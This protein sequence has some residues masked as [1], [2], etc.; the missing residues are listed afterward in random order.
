MPQNS[1]IQVLMSHKYNIFLRKLIISPQK[2]PV[3]LTRGKNIPSEKTPR[4]GPPQIPN[5]AMTAYI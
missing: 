3:E 2:A 4:I 5:I 1:Y